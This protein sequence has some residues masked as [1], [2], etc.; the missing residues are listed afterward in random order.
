MPSYLLQ[1]LD[2]SLRGGAFAVLVLT[3]ALLL[4]DSGRNILARL[5]VV[6][7]LSGAAFAISSMAGMRALLGLWCLPLRAPASA[8]TVVLWL[9]ARKL[10][11][12]GFRLKA[13]HAALW[14]GVMAVCVAHG[15][16][17]EGSA[18]RRVLSLVLTFQAPAFALLAGV[19]ILLTWRGDLVEKRRAAR[20][21]IFTSIALYSIAYTV[22]EVIAERHGVSDG[23]RLDFSVIEAVGLLT[24]ALSGAW[25]LLGTSDRQALQVLAKVMATPAL[26][27]AD[28]A[29]LARLEKMMSV[30]RI[31]RQESLSI[32]ALAAQLD[33]PEY[34]L[35]RL[36]NQGLGHRNFAGFVNSYRI[37]D[38]KAGL[39][40]PQ[41]AQVPILTIALDAGFA[42]LGPFNRAFKAETG[43][44][45]TEFRAQAREAVSEP[46]DLSASRISNSA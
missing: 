39:A 2:W 32:G 7:A 13:W 17:P 23:A 14:A 19:H 6:L 8:L 1:S 22:M 18:P 25:S 28:Q 40:D 38:A 34:R 16:M 37:N 41:Q 30:E 46:S 27:V 33:L 35:R 45:P 15:L 11:D 9:S 43:L 31:Y 44:T 21:S 10:F 20:A 4:R 24:I 36:I 3:A 5:A 29:L 42:S 12:D 26:T